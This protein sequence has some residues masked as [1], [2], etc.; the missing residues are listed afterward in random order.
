MFYMIVLF[1]YIVFENLKEVIV[2]YEEVFG[3]IDVK[4]LEVGEE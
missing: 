3:V 4:C 2:Y 1:F